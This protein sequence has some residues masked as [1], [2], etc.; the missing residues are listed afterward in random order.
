VIRKTSCPQIWPSPNLA[1]AL[2][3]F[4]F[5]NPARSDSGQIW[6]SEI[7]Y[8]TSDVWWLYIDCVYGLLLM[9]VVMLLMLLMLVVMLLLIA[10]SCSP[11]FCDHPASQH[12]HGC[13]SAVCLSV[14]LSVCLSVCLLWF[15]VLYCLSLLTSEIVKSAAGLESTHVSTSVASIQTF[16]FYLY[17]ATS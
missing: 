15:I 5:P 7:L 12:S 4:E 9:L 1:P 13:E 14:Y 2:A 6:S 11:W 16:T 10:E 17:L 3:G 8:N